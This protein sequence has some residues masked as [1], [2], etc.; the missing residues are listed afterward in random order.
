LSYLLL[1]I[2][3]S[4][5]F[6]G[7]DR[8]KPSWSGDPCKMARQQEAP[9]QTG[10]LR[11][12]EGK[13][14]WVVGDLYTILASGDD[15]GGA[16]AL[17]HA[18]VPPGGGPP[19]HIHRREDE[20]FYILEGEI[21]CNVDGRDIVATAGV[22]VTLAKGSLHTFK[23]TAATTAKMLIVVTP[24]GLEQYFAEVGREATDRSSAPPVTQADIEKLLAVAPRYGMEIRL[25]S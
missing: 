15:T 4:Q 10:S 7:E 2:L 6:A 20:A 22:W 3:H 8:Q 23:N 17:I 9:M 12:G 25:P 24:S 5:T 21:A 11:P 13:A 18:I 1:D 14:Y 16:Y 19:P